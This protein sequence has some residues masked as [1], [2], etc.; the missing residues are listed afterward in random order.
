MATVIHLTTLPLSG[1]SNT[2]AT[3]GGKVTD[4][5]GGT[6]TSVGIQIQKGSETGRT[7]ITHSYGGINV[8]FVIPITGLLPET[9]YSIVAYAVTT[10]G[11]TGTTTNL[12]SAVTFTT[13]PNAPQVGKITQP[14]SPNETG[15][16]SFINLPNHANTLRWSGTATGSTGGF[17]TGVTVTGLTVGTYLFSIKTDLSPYYSPATTVTIKAT[18][19]VPTEINSTGYKL[20]ERNGIGDG[21]AFDAAFAEIAHTIFVEVTY[22]PEEI[23][24]GNI[25]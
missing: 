5:T 24:L 16:I 6:V 10:T 20:Y 25:K 8:P 13:A 19:N 3:S 7:T 18:E 21:A 17:T 15:S 4:I 23:V 2:T 1:V 22:T 12:D 14:I 9:F 11:G